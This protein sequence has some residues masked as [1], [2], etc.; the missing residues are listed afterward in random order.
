MKP[1][2]LCSFFTIAAFLLAGCAS[3]TRHV[4]SGGSRTV[5]NVGK[6][7]IQ[8]WNMAAESMINSLNDKF[9]NAGKLQSSTT[10]APAI[11]AISKIVNNTGQQIDTDLLVKK[12]RIAL[13]DTGK[14]VT[15][16]TA[17][18]GGPEDPLAKEAK[19]REILLGTQK[20]IRRPD[21]TLSGKI[22][23]D[24]ANAGS[25]NEATY[26]FQLSLTSRD[27]LA[28]W[29]EERSIT[30]QGKKASVGW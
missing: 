21:Y 17:G 5:L 10:G 16:V 6:I 2:S 15:D 22:I 7:N 8:D 13:N 9:V 25:V 27:G 11:L 19:E 3:G 12:I 30:K 18:L 1:I 20:T 24:R 23:E 28:I 4:E 26:V 14:V 29:E